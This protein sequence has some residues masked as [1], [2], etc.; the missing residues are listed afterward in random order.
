M[1]FS[2]RGTQVRRRHC[3]WPLQSGF[4]SSAPLLPSLPWAALGEGR[5]RGKEASAA[6]DGAGKGWGVHTRRLT[7][8]AGW[9][10][11]PGPAVL[12]AEWGG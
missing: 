3:F 2:S 10:E 9:G 7:A 1:D 4:D 12:G 8:R 5:V 11:A 6:V